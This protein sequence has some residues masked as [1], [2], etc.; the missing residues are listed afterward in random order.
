[1]TKR[2]NIYL[3]LSL[4]L[5]AI[6]IGYD[7]LK[8]N[9]T[10]IDRY[11]EQIQQS[12]HLEEEKIDHF[13]EDKAFIQRI[14][15]A[16]RYSLEQEES[17][18][19][20]LQEL[21]TER[22]TLSIFKG[23]SLIFWNNNYARLPVEETVIKS[24]ERQ[25]KFLRL[26]NGF[27][28]LVAQTFRD[29]IMGQYSVYALIPIKHEYEL[30]S[31]YLNNDFLA[32]N[33]IPQNIKLTHSITEFPI[34]TN[35]GAPL[36][37]LEADGKL[38]NRPVQQTLLVLYGFAFFFL[39]LL[40]HSLAKQIMQSNRPWLGAAFLILTVFG[41]R[42]LTLLF[43]FSE[44]FNALPLFA[45]N[46]H[47]PWSRT[48]GDLLINIVLL[49]WMM[50]FFHRE[51][52]IRTFSHLA[53]KVRFG[54][55]VLNY[56]SIILGILL[57][58]GVFKTLVFNSGI[59]FNFDNVFDLNRYSLISIIGVIL[60]L[61][62]LFMFSHRMMLAI[63]Q[64]GF[65]KYKRLWALGIA[66]ILTFP[67]L[68]FSEFLLPWFFLSVLAALLILIFD[69][70]I[71]S[72]KTNFTWLVIWLVI[73]AAFPSFLLFIYNAYKDR[74]VRLSYAKELA[75]LRDPTA[76]ISF[77]ELRKW[78]G[79][80]PKIQSELA[81]PFPFKADEK[82]LTQSINRYFSRDNYLFYN[83]QYRISAFNKYKTPIIEDQQQSFDDFDFKLR[84]STPT[85][86]YSLRFWK[87]T[88]VKSWAYLMQINIPVVSNPDDE[89]S[90][91][92]EF[93]RNRREQSKVYTELL[94]DKPYKT[95]PDLGK[96]EYAVYKNRERY[97][98]EGKIYGPTL[99]INNLPEVGESKELSFGNRS[100][101]IYKAD[102]DTVV[103]IGRDKETFIKAI[104]LFSYIFGMLLC[105][106]IGFS[107]INTFFHILPGTL[108]FSHFQK[109]SLKNRIQLAVISLTVVSFISIGIV[110]VWFFK[111][112]S[113]EYHEKRLA[114]KTSSVLTDTQHEIEL[115]SQL[116]SSF[117]IR[118]ILKPISII[119]RID[120]NL[121]DTNGQLTGSSEE[122]FFNK[123]IVDRR[124][125]AVA[126]QALSK[127]GLSEFIQD[128]E[129]MGAL[130]YKSAYVPLK[131]TN[132][133]VIAYMGL[134]YYSKQSQLRNDVTVFMSTLL[135]VYVFLLLIAG[136]I[137]FAT[138]DSITRPLVKI[139]EKL[140]DLKLGK[141]NEPLDWRS[142]D[143][144]GAL[145]NEYNKMIIKLQNSA[146]KLAQSE[147][148]GAW[149]EM[150][151]QVAHEIKNP[152]TPMKLSIQ[153]LQHAYQS[154]PDNIEP[155]LKRVSATLIEQIDNLAQIAS[156]FSNF[157]KMPRAENQKTLLNG[158]IGS[159]F[160]L[161]SNEDVELSLE[162][163]NEQFF[164]YADKNH[165]VR[166]F[167]N[168]IKNAIQAIPDER[169]GQVDVF[170][171]KKSGKAIVR[172]KDNGTG[173]A[174]DKREKVFVP[175]FTT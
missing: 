23:D 161:F 77:A 1:M 17:D 103:I 156:E 62:S 10:K 138:A 60:L 107:I 35:S 151:K 66:S 175:N 59:T 111:T 159:V 25:N 47:S 150:A 18:F 121:Y 128:G 149:R 12:L 84:N 26:P 8:V 102:K 54:L 94:V 131:N 122:D 51:Y 39:A 91:V 32:G 173:I 89:L 29:K 108:D 166:V 42:I 74:V 88:E 83:Y 49:L 70:F 58:T 6:A 78:L 20:A 101:V 71:D 120:I 79:N 16:V 61:I 90:L 24:P 140:K 139:G 68:W 43:G 48:L 147:R 28:E 154:T 133:Q 95:L 93:E 134:P 158:L 105:F 36:C 155:L 65:N 92:L 127:R 67:I 118:S 31:N 148:E 123:G 145:I 169:R 19:A 153:Y 109:P 171:Y 160:D 146:D 40:L 124:M 104:S 41:L 3:S 53:P 11:Q 126:F 73:L 15:K 2:Q 46:F 164:V 132:D 63:S 45:E 162:L 4:L 57:L 52:P 21:A 110:T 152:L 96:Y 33:H 141:R 50:I 80:D 55:T 99:T 119:H 85:E 13:L 75:E 136:G 38:V 165:L 37:Y 114:R 72:N 56:L 116:D 170:L 142:N 100:E 163:P 172:V 174:E 144:L 143:E 157:A 82:V 14:T 34:I 167:N 135:N 137:A 98:S 112:S 9:T 86:H 106:M 44:Q 168:L 125:G 130:Q 76:E 97:D 22:F 27:F 115:L 117:D 129:R 113:E 87:D 30:Q 5:L 7:Y 81:K 69:L 64:M